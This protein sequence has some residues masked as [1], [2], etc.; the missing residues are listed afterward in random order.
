MQHSSE[1]TKNPEEIRIK[2]AIELASKMGYAISFDELSL[3]MKEELSP[4]EILENIQAYKRLYD[5]LTV[6]NDLAVLKGY[7]KLFLERLSRDKVSK[8]LLEVAKD[9]GR[10]VIQ[11]C[12]HL[13][14]IA[15]TGSIAYNSALKSDDIDFFIVTK[16]KRLWLSIL[17]F[18]ILARAFHFKAFIE[19]KKVKI[20][21]SYAITEEYLTKEMRTR[22][23]PLIARE[24]LSIH[25]LAGS[26]YYTKILEKNRWIKKIFPIFYNSK[27][28]KSRHHD[29]P[30]S[31]TKTNIFGNASN[32]AVHKFL[33]IY[34][35]IKA[36]TLNLSFKKHCRFKDTFEA[37]ITLDSL[38][39]TSKKYHEIEKMYEAFLD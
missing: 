35:S 32:F 15:V 14:L 22:K 1:E 9:F 3:L 20:C 6:K 29:K 16:T 17:K 5:L 34:L 24:F 8:R 19:G 38:V 39:Y 7:E 4:A 2:V 27:L 33:M 21:L 31:A 23:T 10:Q 25:L 18:L 26:N 13:K 30:I 36:F 11:Y 37:T 12:P 28:Q